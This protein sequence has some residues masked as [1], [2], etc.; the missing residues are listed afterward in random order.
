MH[1]NFK[2]LIEKLLPDVKEREDFFACY[3]NLLPKSIKIIEHKITADDFL[4]HVEWLWRT[5]TSPPFLENNDSWYIE[6]E[7]NE[8]ALGK[9]FLHAAGFFYIQEV[10]ASL[11]VHA[12]NVEAGDIILDMC[13]A[14]G[15][16]STQLADKLLTLDPS[17]PW[18]VVSNEISSSRIVA[19]Q[20]NLNRTWVYNSAV[21]RLDGAKFGELLP[22]FFDKILVDAPCSGEGTWFKSD[23][24]TK[25]RREENV[26]EIAKLQYSLLVS[27]IKACK[28][29]GEIVY[30]TCTLNTRENEGVIAQVLK[31]YAGQIELENI[32]IA[33]KSTWI[34]TADS[35]WELADNEL[36]K[37]V[38]FWP[39]RQHTGGFFIAKLRKNNSQ[40]TDH[41][42]PWKDIKSITKNKSSFDISEKLQTKIWALLYDEYGITI[43]PEKHF[44]VS[45]DKQIYL[46]SPAY[47]AF[48]PILYVEKTWIPIFK[49]HNE[50]ELH[51]LHGLGNCVWTMATKNTI[52]LSDEQCQRY[53]EG[54]DIADSNWQSTVGNRYIILQWEWKWFS[55]GKIVWD[56]IKNKFAK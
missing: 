28:P 38:R 18:L 17:K 54:Y 42:S 25:R 32:D 48:H 27:A 47:K 52:S 26:K 41:N 5:L 6:R 8:L 34:Q 45:T 23:A 15:G 20:S 36:Q 51:P 13:A 44:F 55:V 35:G 50:S 11:A 3:N 40:I 2:D 9:H 39:H 49:R 31:E 43:D 4:Q 46:T 10:A 19:L 12:V 37:L 14:P 22:D 33:N 56:T 16:K 30:A 7:N 29:W 24:S 21:T 53:S 1:D